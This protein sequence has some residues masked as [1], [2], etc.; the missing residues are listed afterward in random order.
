LSRDWVGFP[1]GKD[2]ETRNAISAVSFDTLLFIALESGT[3]PCKEP[4][5][6]ALKMPTL[7]NA[8]IFRKEAADI[9]SLHKPIA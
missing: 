7:K 4:V 5:L 6:V 3:I 8:S 9:L 1:L 2:I